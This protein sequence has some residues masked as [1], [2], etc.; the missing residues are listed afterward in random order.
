MSVAFRLAL[1]ALAL[2]SQLLLAESALSRAQYVTGPCQCKMS[3]STDTY[4]E[5]ICSKKQFHLACDDAKQACVNA[6]TAN[7]QGRMTHGGTCSG[8]GDC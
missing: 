4:S 6:N 1:V 8:G 5:T 3:N 7:C 2:S